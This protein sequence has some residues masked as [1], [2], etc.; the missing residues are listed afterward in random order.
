M[1]LQKHDK[2]NGKKKEPPREINLEGTTQKQTKCLCVKMASADKSARTLLPT[3]A[4]PVPKPRHK[5]ILADVA[6]SARRMP[7]EGAFF[8]PK[9]GKRLMHWAFIVYPE[10]SPTDWIDRLRSQGLV[11]FISPLHTPDEEGR[12]PHH[13]VMLRFPSVKSASQ[14]QDIAE[15]VNGSKV[16]EP[17]QDWRGYARYLLH[18]DQPNKQQF[19]DASGI[20]S[21]GGADYSAVVTQTGRVTAE[22]SV[23][24]EIMQ[25]VKEQR[26]VHFHRAVEWMQ[27]SGHEDWL[28]WLYE[29]PRGFGWLKETLKSIYHEQLQ[30]GRTDSLGATTTPKESVISNHSPILTFRAMSEE[31]PK[32]D[33]ETRAKMKRLN[34][35]WEDEKGK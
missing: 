12:K 2:K 18:L 24:L 35:E 16:V 32:V 31:S 5:T 11:G 19:A 28:N 15:T 1:D 8:M 17:V 29:N 3:S 33:D 23:V 9:K 13:H 4:Y 34:D 14:I 25:A 20:V 26:L 10:S 6:K 7:L 21:L 22:M 30:V 27:E